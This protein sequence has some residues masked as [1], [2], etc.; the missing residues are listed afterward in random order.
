MSNALAALGPDADR[1]TILFVTVDPERDTV[2]H[3]KSYLS[4]FDQRIIG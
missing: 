2:E 3:L 4:A 1:L